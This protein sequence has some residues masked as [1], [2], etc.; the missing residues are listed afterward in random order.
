MFLKFIGKRGVVNLV[1]GVRRW[2]TRSTTRV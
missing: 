2:K 1:F